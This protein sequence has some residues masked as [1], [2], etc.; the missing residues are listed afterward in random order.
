[1]EELAAREGIALAAAPRTL[2]SG[3]DPMVVERLVDIVAS[4]VG[5]SGFEPKSR[6]EANAQVAPAPARRARRR[7]DAKA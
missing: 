7:G 3:L 6:S 4:R 2:A 1:M 5:L